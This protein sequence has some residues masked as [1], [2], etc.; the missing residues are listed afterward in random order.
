M[1]TAVIRIALI[2]GIISFM[3]LSALAASIIS[4]LAAWIVMGCVRIAERVIAFVK[5]GHARQEI[6]VL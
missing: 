5:K 1:E 4:G 6:P 3:I 2:S